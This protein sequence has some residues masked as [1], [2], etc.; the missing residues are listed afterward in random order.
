MRNAA[1]LAFTVVALLAVSPGPN[2]AAQAGW[3]TLF[4]GTTLKGGLELLWL[5]TGKEDFLLETSRR[6]VEM[7]GSHGLDP[8]YVETAG[9][10]TWIVWRDYLRDSAQLIFDPD[11]VARLKATASA[12]KKEAEAAPA[13][14]AGAEAA[15]TGA[16]GRV[17][18]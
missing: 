17:R 6:T 1:V 14:G 12:R 16:R 15:V 13:A 9:G 11:A 7:L 2:V 18:L 3:T 10:H 4:D 5:A 8:I